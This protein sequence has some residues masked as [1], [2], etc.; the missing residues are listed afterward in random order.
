MNNRHFGEL[1]GQFGELKGQFGELKGQF[2]SLVE[3]RTV[4]GIG[5]WF[6]E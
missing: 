5:E 2:D 4:W 1:K 3:G 6:G